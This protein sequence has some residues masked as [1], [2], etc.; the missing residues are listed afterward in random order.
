MILDSNNKPKPNVAGLGEAL[1]TT[2]LLTVGLAGILLFVALVGAVARVIA[3]A[4]PRCR[5]CAA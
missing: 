4:T 2:H 5:P 1:Y 3:A